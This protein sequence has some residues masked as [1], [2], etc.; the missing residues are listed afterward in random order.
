MA[1]EKNIDVED[2]KINEE[3]NEVYVDDKVSTDE[4]LINENEKEEVIDNNEKI[5]IESDVDKEK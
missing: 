1:A 5:V 2:V 3:T 4:K